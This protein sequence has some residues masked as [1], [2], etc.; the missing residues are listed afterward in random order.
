MPVRWPVVG[1]SIKVAAVAIA[2]FGI[3]RYFDV[4]HVAWVHYLPYGERSCRLLMAYL[5]SLRPKN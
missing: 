3:G 2:V 5:L 4:L 1:K